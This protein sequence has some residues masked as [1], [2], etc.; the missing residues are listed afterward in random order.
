MLYLAVG[1]FAPFSSAIL[2]RWGI[3]RCLYIGGLGHFCLVFASILPSLKH[4]EA[5]G[6]EMGFLWNFLN[7]KYGESV[8]IISVF[9]AAI[10]NG[11]GASIL[12]TAQ[13]EYVSRCGNIESKGFFFGY[14][15]SIH[16]AS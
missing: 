10:L 6:D 5:V 13:G 16:Q 9:T 2:K 4:E 7:G 3:K 11:F 8:V 14:F 12:W 1:L 15:W